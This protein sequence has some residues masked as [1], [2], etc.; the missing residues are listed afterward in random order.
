MRTWDQVSFV[1]LEH[2]TF[3]A[4]YENQS[5]LELGPSLIGRFRLLKRH[6]DVAA[7]TGT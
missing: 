1:V 2:Y 6:P 3:F 7:M 4:S 5:V